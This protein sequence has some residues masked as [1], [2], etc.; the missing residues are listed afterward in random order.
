MMN[1]RISK[2]LN[3]GQY[4]SLLMG[5]STQVN[6]LGRGSGKSVILMAYE[7][8]MNAYSMPGGATSLLGPSYQKMLVDLIPPMQTGWRDL[9]NW[10][11]G[12]HYVI[13][14]RPPKN[15]PQTFR[16]PAGNR[17]DYCIATFTG[18]IFHIVSQDKSVTDNGKE[19]C[20]IIVD[21]AKLIDGKQFRTQTA[22][23]V[24][25]KDYLWGNNPRYNSF[26]FYTDRLF[27]NPSQGWLQEYIDQV[28]PK[29]LQTIIE[30]Q[31]QIDKLKM[32]NSTPHHIFQLDNLIAKM[33]MKFIGFCESSSFDNMFV[34]GVGFYENQFKILLPNEFDAAIANK[35]VKG[36]GDYY[37]NLNED[38]HGYDDI[39]T[40]SNGL[41][42]DLEMMSN[43]NS[44]MDA[45]CRP[46]LP[47]KFSMDFGG[48]INTL[49]VAQD[50]PHRVNIINSFFAKAPNKLKDVVNEACD[51]YRHHPTRLIEFYYDPYGNNE[52]ADDKYTLAEKVV[53]YLH[54]NGFEVQLMNRVLKNEKHLKRIDLWQ[55]ILHEANGQTTNDKLPR[56]FRMNKLKCTNVFISMKNAK[57][58]TGTTGKI[59]K[60]KSSES[61]NSKIP[62][63]HAT[64]FSDAIDALFIND[65]LH[66]LDDNNEVWTA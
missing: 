32:N 12:T 35:S 8:A 50:L 40:F 64:H 5:C 62:Q 34:N 6:Y 28:N 42:D 23:T 14:K 63:E 21:E 58:K 17:W 7:T 60:D 16:P 56:V 54:D 38:L 1:Q 45:D 48:R 65:Y 59:E 18:H 41:A 47:L 43:R 37:A 29:A 10:V 9:F 19:V 33:R 22:P 36:T 25:G 20:S 15:W 31:L 61:I 2:Y 30:L 13:G 44:L 53:Q 66:L 11:E 49:I 27:T 51:Y 39:D 26:K 24:R 57:I 3:A 46:D 4:R 52:Q 55:N